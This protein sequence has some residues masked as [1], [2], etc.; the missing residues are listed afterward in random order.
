MNNYILQ[1]SA[2]VIGSRRFRGFMC[3]MVLLAI[4]ALTHIG[5]HFGFEATL[6][7]YGGMKCELDSF[8]SWEFLRGEG[9]H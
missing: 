5:N 2:A 6:V 1:Q 3:L 7:L 9:F 4:L 8:S